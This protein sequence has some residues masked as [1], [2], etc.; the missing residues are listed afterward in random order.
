MSIDSLLIEVAQGN[1]NNFQR[2]LS[3]HKNNEPVS[4]LNL[5]GK[6]PKSSRRECIKHLCEVLKTNTHIKE[7]F[8]GANDINDEDVKDIAKLVSQNKTLKKLSLMD[9]QIGNQGVKHLSQS[10]KSN[11]SLE[12][13]LLANNRISKEGLSYLGESFSSNTTLKYLDISYNIIFEADIEL[14]L[15][16]ITSQHA[17]SKIGVRGDH[18]SNN[19]ASE[20]KSILNHYKEEK[21][22]IAKATAAISDLLPQP[23]AEE[24]LPQFLYIKSKDSAAAIHLNALI[25][26]RVALVEPLHSNQ[27]QTLT[28]ALKSELSRTT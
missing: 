25:P 3:E 21:L 5:T 18:L 6:L 11:K 12:K 19:L 15:K 17:L 2:Y 27:R 4:S 24:I 26:Q 14:L 28:Q 10:L 13:L 8:L 1:Y 9:N 23:I 7:L 22:E 20:M 16:S